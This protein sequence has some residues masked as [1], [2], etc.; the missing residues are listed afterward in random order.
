ML[1]T[2]P[3]LAG[4]VALAAI[5]T[6]AAAENVN[7]YSYRQAVLMKPLLDRFEQ[8]TGVKAQVVY[9]KRGMIARLEAEGA[10]SPAD[11]I[12]TTDA[13]RLIQL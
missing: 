4:A 9:L 5:G 1:R 12:L 7:I 11:V 13:A 8:K 3:I 6:A 2:L 10:A